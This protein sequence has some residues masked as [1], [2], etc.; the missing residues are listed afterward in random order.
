MKKVLKLF[1]AL[2][3]TTM[4]VV[5]CENPVYDFY[6]TT[7]IESINLK[8]SAYPGVNI[9]TWKALKDAATY[10]VYRSTGNGDR[11]EM[12]MEPSSQTYYYDV[13]I[14]DDTEYK[15]RVVATP[16]DLT[17]HDASQKEVTL[18]TAKISENGTE[19][20][21]KWAPTATS[22]LNLA[23]YES[24]Y[25]EKDPILSNRTISAKLMSNTGSTVRVKFPTK[26]YA[27]YVVTL[28]QVRGINLYDINA[29]DDAKSVYGWNCNGEAT[30]DLTAVYS[31]EKEISVTA[32]PLNSIYK[33]DTVISSSSVTVI[34]YDDIDSATLTSV[35]VKW[36][37]YNYSS[38]RANSRVYF[39]PN[40]YNNNFFAAS[41]YTIYR[42]II[43]TNGETIN[44]KLVYN[45]IE[46]LGTPKVD[47]TVSINNCPEYYFDD[48]VTLNSDVSKVKYYVV[49]NHDGKIKTG[50]AVLTVPENLDEDWNFE[51]TI[52]WQNRVSFND[53]YIDLDGRINAVVNS[54]SY[55]S[56]K[57]TYGSFATYNQAE[58]AV[59]KELPNTITLSESGYYNYY[60]GISSGTVDSGK[61]YAFRLL[62][63]NGGSYDVVKTLIA[64]A[65]NYDGLYYWNIRSG[66][67][68][69][70]TVYVS[71]PSISASKT[72]N[73]SGTKYDSITLDYS[74]T[75]AHYYKIYRA[76]SYYDSVPYDS[77]YTLLTTTAETTYFDDDE[78]L[79]DTN[80]DQYVFYK[81]VAVGY[82]A[83]AGTNT[84]M[85]SAL[86]APQVYRDGNIIQWSDVNRATRYYIYRATSESD[87]DYA[88]VYTSTEDSYY[89][90]TPSYTYD[91]YYAVKA[92]SSYEGEYSEFSELVVVNKTVMSEL[93]N[94]DNYLSWAE[95]N[96]ATR[97]D[98]YRATSE[99][100]LVY[101]SRYTTTTNNYYTANISFT[102]DY[103]Y[104]IKAYNGST[105]EYTNLSNAVFIS[106]GT[107]PTVTNLEV[108]SITFDGSSYSYTL[109]WDAPTNAYYNGY[110]VLCYSGALA[111]IEEA[112]EYFNSFPS[113]IDST[114]NIT[115][116]VTSLPTGE[117]VYYAL[118]TSTTDSDTGNTGYAVS[119]V[120]ELSNIFSSESAITATVSGG[121]F[122]IS[123][124]E[125]SNAEQYF[126]YC[127]S[128]PNDILEINEDLIAN[129]TDIVTTNSYSFTGTALYNF[130]LVAGVNAD[131]DVVGVT[132][133]VLVLNDN[134]TESDWILSSTGTYSFDKVAETNNWTS[135]NAGINS[136]TA[137]TTWTISLVYDVADY[138]IPYVVSSESG[139]DEFALT[140]DGSDILVD[141]SGEV[142]NSYTV[143]LTAGE[144]TLIATYSKDSSAESGSDCATITLNPVI[145]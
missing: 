42:S 140:L 122:S 71:E 4:L 60:Y 1:G 53:I 11:E 88:S 58:V 34:D 45:S 22:F 95:V 13:A 128:Q 139:Y 18:R 131:G 15:Y 121:V 92:Y 39:V 30:V 33:Y 110:S 72:T 49:L 130:F 52:P 111:T 109:S 74:A 145:Y 108:S 37:N 63:E 73:T 51:P 31:G 50:S 14:D 79:K 26:P 9:L 40:V 44:D 17:V 10:T 2:L 123:W 99:D 112:V 68:D 143:T 116:T 65:Q 54:N 138:E 142:E 132:E 86:M 19:K 7:T 129:Y 59:E 57:L 113:A 114:I 38:K 98:I 105:Y 119:N 36:T 97:Y 91:Y 69:N 125:M 103:Y 126:V 106:K 80:L 133:P 8:A 115:Y 64:Q 117:N 90:I 120:V 78:T 85:V 83:Y 41:E 118:R 35:G 107:V 141:V 43:G 16:S 61:Y 124:D 70:Y 62:Y 81:V 82:Y 21:G 135:N 47:K 20:K 76:I 67:P 32:I 24:N 75:N 23:E 87:L 89:Y 136:S 56:L 29:I 101:A 100:D 104:A 66:N 12:V 77:S 25:N 94:T 127:V 28:G 96:G 27:A 134:V 48:T 137:S 5:S 3:I 102:N 6:P 144:H 84:K 55:G 46:K 93:Y